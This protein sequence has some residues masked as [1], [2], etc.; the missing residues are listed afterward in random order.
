MISLRSGVYLQMVY[1][2][3]LFFDTQETLLEPCNRNVP[4]TPF[5][6]YFLGEAGQLYY[7][8]IYN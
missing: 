7:N 5:L 8:K 1:A 6:Y 3:C 2:M 4:K